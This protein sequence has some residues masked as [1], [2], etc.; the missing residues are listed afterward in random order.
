MSDKEEISGEEESSAVPPCANQSYY[1]HTKETIATD[2]TGELLENALKAVEQYTK[3]ITVMMKEPDTNTEAVVVVTSQ[4]VQ[5]LPAAVFDDY[6]KNPKHRIGNAVMTRLDSF[7]A[8]VNRFK[9]DESAIF[10]NEGENPSLTA[11][12]DYHDAVNVDGEEFSGMPQFCRHRTKFQFPL[13]EE[14]EAWTGSNGAKMGIIELAA[15]LEDRINDIIV[16]DQDTSLSAEMKQFIAATGAK[17]ATP[18]KMMELSRGISIYENSNVTDVRNLSSGEAQISFQ[19]DHVDAD[20]KPVAIPNLFMICI[21]VFANDTS[22][23]RIAARLRY[24]KRASEILFWYD[25]WRVDKVFSSAFDEACERVRDAT[26]L[27]V[28][29]GRSEA[30]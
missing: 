19:S 29:I 5:P 17:I 13:S 15:F 20:G 7:T 26:D 10:A 28:F 1:S 6:R 3:P 18:T 23:Y 30:G 27:P 24:R 9:N 21:P 12:I 8:H 2:R 4:G 14:W 16:V 25:L 22:Y 11:I